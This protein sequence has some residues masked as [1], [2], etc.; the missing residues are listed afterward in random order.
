MKQN[1]LIVDDQ[2]M[3]NI[4]LSRLLKIRGYNALSALNGSSAFNILSDKQ[5]DMILLDIML[6]EESGMDLLLKFADKYPRIPVIMITA[7]GT[8]STAVISMQA[9][10]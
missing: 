8:I 7:Y 9:V 3:H 2:E 1:I 10:R 4:S 5:I 6:G